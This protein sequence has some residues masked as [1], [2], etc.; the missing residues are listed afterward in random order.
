MPFD[1]KAVLAK[2]RELEGLLREGWIPPVVFPRVY[3]N[4]DAR[5]TERARQ[6]LR[7]LLGLADVT[8]ACRTYVEENVMVAYRMGLSPE[9]TL[10][11]VPRELEEDEYEFFD[12]SKTEEIERIMQIS[13][14][15]EELRPGERELIAE[16]GRQIEEKYPK[17]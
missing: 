4:Y 10:S 1:K 17:K 11:P 6:T 2:F 15:F 14:L 13:A 5:Y 7:N 8:E 3:G 16:W 9:S 12:P